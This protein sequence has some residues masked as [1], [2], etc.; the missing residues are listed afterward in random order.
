MITEDL[1]FITGENILTIINVNSYN[2]VR[3]IN[4]P[5]STW[6]NVV[7]MLNK[8][9]LLTADNNRRIQQWR[10]NGDNLV[11]ISIKQNACE[12]SIGILLKLEGYAI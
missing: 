10:I 7:C 5:D 8:N 9:I 4:V 11:L 1:L 2:A 12:N 3:T 6:I